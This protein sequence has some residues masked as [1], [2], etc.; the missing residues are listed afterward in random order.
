MCDPA[1]TRKVYLK[2]TPEK[3]VQDTVLT[4]TIVLPPEL[5]DARIPLESRSVWKLGR[6]DANNIVIADSSVSRNHAVLQKQADGFYLI[7]MGSRNGCFVNGSRVSIPIVLRDGDVLQF[8]EHQLTFLQETADAPE[9][10]PDN[11]GDATKV[12][13]AFSLITILVVDIRDFTGLT[14]QID[15]AVLCETIGSWFREGGQIMQRR[16]SWSQ[17]YIGDAVMSIW[18]HRNAADAKKDIIEVLEALSEFEGVSSDFQ[19]R[20]GLPAPFRVGAGINTG[21]ASIGNAGSGDVNDFT[22]VGD[23]VNAAFR[24]ESA[25][26]ELGLDVALGQRTFELLSENPAAKGI[27]EERTV[28]LKGYA[29]PAQI[30]GTRFAAL[31]GLVAS[32]RAI[33]N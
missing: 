28:T 33:K 3:L 13:F 23:T 20:F 29:R 7:D 10:T 6:S 32:S 24:M 9:K 18:V 16:G 4:A 30:W 21:H 22:A 5:G 14:Q 8:G 19:K 2:V 12:I 15:K 17:K 25:T 1:G 26:K 11:V 31:P 27:L